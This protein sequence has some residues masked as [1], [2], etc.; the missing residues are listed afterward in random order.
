VRWSGIVAALALAFAAGFGTALALRSPEAAGRPSDTA[1][2]EPPS[3]SSRPDRASLRHVRDLEGKLAEAA[4]A[5]ESREEQIRVLELRV[6]PPATPPKQPPPPRD[7]EQIVRH[8]NGETASHGAWKDGLKEGLWTT[9][10]TSGART[11]SG[12][13]RAG[14]RVGKW[15]EWK[16]GRPKNEQDWVAG[17]KHGPFAPGI[18]AGRAR[19]KTARDTVSGRPG[20]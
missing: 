4:R 15:R 13:Y 11:S 16:Y 12:H 18:L 17:R 6:T 10:D 19:T 7:G 1:S 3:A 2:K 14:K 9:Y 8:P 5:L 20:T